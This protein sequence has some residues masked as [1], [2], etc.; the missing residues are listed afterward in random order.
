MPAGAITRVA[1]G[2][3]AAGVFVPLALA[4]ALEAAGSEE[5]AATRIVRWTPDGVVSL[6]PTD[7]DAGPIARALAH[8]A[9]AARLAVSTDRARFATTPS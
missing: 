8:P 9:V 5:G 2:V 6:A 7:A 1:V 3:R 4:P